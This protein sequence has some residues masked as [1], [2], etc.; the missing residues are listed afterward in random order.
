MSEGLWLRED[1]VKM[2]CFS[3]RIGE[4]REKTGVL[5]AVVK[6]V[7]EE[8]NHRFFLLPTHPSAH[9][10]SIGHPAMK[11]VIALVLALL[12]V[13]A[14][15]DVRPW[16][17]TPESN[18][19]PNE[20]IVVFQKHLSPSARLRHMNHLGIQNMGRVAEE[21]NINDGEFQAYY[22]RDVDMNSALAI[23]EM[24]E[25]Q[26]IEPAQTFRIVGDDFACTRDQARS[27]GLARTVTPNLPIDNVQYEIDDQACGQGVDL[28]IM[29]TG[30][31]VT[32]QD[33]G[34]RA[35]WGRDFTGEGENDRHGHGTHVASTA[36]GS[37]YG[38]ARCANLVAVKVCNGGGS[39]PSNAI[40]SGV[41]F[42]A[43]AA[44]QGNRKIVGNMSLG[45]GFSQ[46]SNGTFLSP[47]PSS[48][49][50]HQS[51]NTHH[52]INRSHPLPD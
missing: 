15:A 6:R 2:M 51:I 52:R 47:I 50:P 29:D 44:R 20:Y 36:G 49:H 19:I 13:G 32:H 7:S 43:D 33:F 39:C 30:I 41:Q 24:P 26:Y 4:G 31:Q 1:D 3:C 48:H 27:W 46:A 10:Q 38:L 42:T 8:M 14:F 17:P 16:T 22:L 23:Q 5:C 35:R 25:V 18:I 28:Y 21:W 40:L 11:K 45:G 37:Q 9:H 34:G 12:C